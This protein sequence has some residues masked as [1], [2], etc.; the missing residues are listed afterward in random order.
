MNPDET[1]L[2]R[3]LLDEPGSGARQR[4]YVDW[5]SQCGDALAEPVQSFPD[6]LRIA[7][8][9]TRKGGSAFDAIE[10]NAKAG[11]FGFLGSML[12]VLDRFRQVSEKE[13]RLDRIRHN[14]LHLERVIALTPAAENAVLLFNRV[15]SLTSPVEMATLIAAGQ[16]TSTLQ[17]LFANP[18][19]A[20]YQSELLSC[21]IQEMVLRGKPVDATQQEGHPLSWLPNRLLDFE[22]G[23]SSCLPR[24]RY[25][26]TSKEFQNPSATGSLPGTPSAPFVTFEPLDVPERIARVVATWPVASNGKIEARAFRADRPIEDADLSA[27]LLMGLGLESMNGD[28]NANLV[29]L[30]TAFN[31][32]FA[33][34]CNG[35]AYSRGLGGAYSRLAAWLSL[36]GLVGADD[37]A[38]CEAIAEAAKRCTWISF[39]STSP[40]FYSVVWDLGI[41]AIWP[42]RRSIAV[43]A[44]T[45]TD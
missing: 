2:L 24:L 1:R 20:R 25:R 15:E 11:N 14:V 8:D 32:L 38:D 16:D 34:A 26:G 44:A 40:W 42:D 36:A 4:A 22:S 18:A 7:A 35:S 30:A 27:Q 6:L 9:C 28:V 31:A 23:L 10:Q 33:A 39:V 45:D 12:S 29:P 17:T 19:G 21:L 41:V 37:S 5:L 13:A 43:L 3:A